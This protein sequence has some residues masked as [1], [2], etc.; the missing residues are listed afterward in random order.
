[1][2]FPLKNIEKLYVSIEKL[3]KVPNEKL[4]RKKKTTTTNFL[5]LFGFSF[6]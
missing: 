5:P 2:V 3:N 6:S 1:M 4:E